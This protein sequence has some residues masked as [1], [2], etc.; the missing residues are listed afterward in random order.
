MTQH[1]AK[2]RFVGGNFFVWFERPH[3]CAV[4]WASSR[5]HWAERATY[6]TIMLFC[7]T[8]VIGAGHCFCRS[9][10]RTRCPC[11]PRWWVRLT[12]LPPGPGDA[13]G[14]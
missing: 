5:K 13:R 6:I 9:E 8:A 4:R 2:M 3:P 10:A 7:C 11:R 12:T 14:R 1:L